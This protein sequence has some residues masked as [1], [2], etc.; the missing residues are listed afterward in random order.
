MIKYTNNVF[1]AD[2]DRFYNIGSFFYMGNRK[3]QKN[4]LVMVTNI[5][6]VTDSRRL[7]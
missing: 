2:N 4:K 5:W 7:M 3:G 1:K 6:M